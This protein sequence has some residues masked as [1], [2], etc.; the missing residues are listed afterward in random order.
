MFKWAGQR[1]PDPNAP[2][3]CKV[4]DRTGSL[5]PYVSP[6]Y[7][8]TLSR[9]DL[10]QRKII[11]TVGVQ[12]TAAMI[13]PWIE[14]MEPFILVGPEGCGKSM[15]I[16]HMCNARR[17]TNIS[18]LHCNAQTTAEHVIQRIRQACSLFSTNSGRVYRPREGDRLVLFL[19]DI[20]LPRPDMYDTCA[21]IA[22]LQQLVTFNGFYDENLEFLGLERVHI[23]CT[24][25]PATTVGRHQLSTRFTAIVRIAFMDYPE[26]SELSSI[27]GAYLQA[28]MQPGASCLVTDPQFRTNAG[29]NQLASTMVELFEQVKSRFSVDEHRHYL[30]TPRDLT[31]WIMGLLRYDMSVESLLDV[32]AHEAQ[33]TFRDRIVNAEGE[34]K[35]DSLLATLLQRQW[36]HRLD[37]NG[38]VYTALGIGGGSRA[39]PAGAGAGAGAGGHDDPS[40]G[41]GDQGTGDGTQGSPLERM[42]IDDLQVL[43]KRGINQFER[44]ERELHML[45]FGETFEHLVRVDRVLSVEG[46]SLLLVGRSGVGRRN[47]ATLVAHMHGMRFFTPSVTRE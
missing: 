9:L 3:D 30:F 14:N 10:E 8:G 28:A 31:S 26:S 23:V 21:L 29:L 13:K 42:S 35:F 43:V 45:L 41:E 47:A 25:N 27:Y 37:L 6:N 38:V 44:E 16:T 18:S 17:G 7:D 12:R 32:L 22:F 40:S 1:V 39:K 4:D 24:M 36:K 5:T 20:N 19:K 34:N 2:L 11:D 33:R 46:G 15:L